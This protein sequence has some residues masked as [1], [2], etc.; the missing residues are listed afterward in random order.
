M[1]DSIQDLLARAVIAATDPDNV[2]EGGPAWTDF[3]R[4]WLAVHLCEGDASDLHVVIYVPPGG[5]YF[6]LRHGPDVTTVH[7]NAG[8]LWDAAARSWNSKVVAVA[9]DALRALDAVAAKD[10]A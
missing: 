9:A 7:V 10:G 4:G 8:V 1:R 2:S 6:V 3:S 5:V